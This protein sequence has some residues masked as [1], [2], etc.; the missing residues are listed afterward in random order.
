MPHQYLALRN[1][2][3]KEGLT[4]KAAQK[5]AARIY[6]SKHPKSPVGRLSREEKEFV[7]RIKR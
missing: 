6:N 7:E 2:F 1:A 5:K 4:K 3:M